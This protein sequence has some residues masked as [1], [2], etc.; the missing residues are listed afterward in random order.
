LGR[1]YL[2]RDEQPNEKAVE[3][4]F[5]HKNAFMQQGKINVFYKKEKKIMWSA[6]GGEGRAGKCYLISFIAFLYSK[7]SLLSTDLPFLFGKLFFH[8]VSKV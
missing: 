1:C 7:I 5:F 2:S 3:I 4:E 8:K 6:E